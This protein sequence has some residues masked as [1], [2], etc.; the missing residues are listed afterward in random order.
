MK[1][2]IETVKLGVLGGGQLGKM[3]IQEAS[4]IGLYIKTLDP[5]K[6]SPAAPYAHKH[7]IG[8]F[9]DYQTVLD[10]GSS[11]DIITVEI[12]QVNVEALK[13]LEENGKTVFPSAG[14]LQTVQDKKRQKD[15]YTF[16]NISTVPFDFFTSKSELENAFLVFPCIWKS[17]MLGYDGKGVKKLSSQ[18]DISS[19]PE[20][21]CIIEEAVNIQKEFSVIVA[22]SA[23]GEIKNYPP[24]EMEFLPERNI[25]SVIKT[26]LALPAGIQ[27]EAT[28]M[29]QEIVKR[30]DI[31]GI[32]A[33][34][35]F[36]TTENTVYVNEIAPRPHNSGHITIDAS[37]ISQYAAHLRA[38]LGFPLGVLDFHSVSLTF[39]L[40]GSENH[41]G[42]AQY[43]G[44]EKALKIP[45]TFLH[46]YGK[47]NTSPY[48]KMG[49]V[50][51]LGNTPKDVSRQLEEFTHIFSIEAE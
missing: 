24:V 35:F 50:T 14:V 37:D 27:E 8:D 22:K 31:V 28:K 38:I 25:V 17:T 2:N 30:M 47:K 12:E 3:L 26:D 23:H 42:N 51:F 29:A 20:T 45:R 18:K 5:N 10:F 4:K 41:T 49:H 21:P 39:N 6:N 13:T 43:L 32:T 44:I 7:V 19:L 36:L 15:F 9:R 46:L 16:H 48:R 34:E 33:V 1:K 11:V 40:L